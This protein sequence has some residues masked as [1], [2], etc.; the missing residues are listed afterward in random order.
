MS[1]RYMAEVAEQASA[2]L[3]EQCGGAAQ[4]ISENMI[5]GAVDRESTALSTTLETE[6][7]NTQGLQSELS[8]LDGSADSTAGEIDPDSAALST[9]SDAETPPAPEEDQGP[10]VQEAGQPAGGN[11]ST[12]NGG[13][14]PVDVVSGQLLIS[15][16]DLALP[17]VLPL[18][19][20]RAYASG[21]EDGGLYGPGWSSTLDI[22]L[23]IQDGAVSFLGDDCQRLE[24]GVPAGLRLGLPSFPAYGAR[25]PLSLEHGGSE[26][27][28]QDPLSRITWCFSATGDAETRPLAAVIDRNGNRI[29]VERDPDGAP[30]RL[31]HDGGYRVAIGMT[32][33]AESLRVTAL[34]LEP[35]EDTQPAIPVLTYEYDEAGKLSRITDSSSVPYVYE[36]ADTGR[37]SGW[38]DR[39]G[40]S[41][42]YT[43]DATGRVVHTEGDGGY[44]TAD[45]TYDP[46]HRATTVTNSLG[47]ATVYHYDRFQHL[48]EVVDQLGEHVL[49][50][51]DRYGRLIAYTD[52]LGNTTSINRDR[53]GNA[54]QLVRA[55]GSNVR[56]RFHDDGQPAE[57]VDASG[58]QWRYAYD[59][60]GN[61][62][63]VTDPLGAV[64]SYSYDE[65]GALTSITDACGA[66]SR[67]EVDAAGLTVAEIDP[68]GAV[69]RMQRDA[70]GRAIALTDPLGA[71]TRAGSTVE[72][73]RLWRENPDGSVDRWEYD[74]AGNLVRHQNAS[75]GA[76]A[77]T[78]GPFN[79]VRSRTD[80][81]GAKYSA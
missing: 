49:V 11:D 55:D 44:L 81:T 37:I 65:R 64:Q 48:T 66:T 16:T 6:A 14:D 28:V 36:W 23:V 8:G 25:W 67:Y 58:G 13:T 42:R 15:T 5:D 56:T 45:L 38:V 59:E 76:T 4:A 17:G 22:R 9:P 80:P 50:R 10:D 12:E 77:F 73:R 21:Y 74:P 72:G 43:Y 2:D 29:L 57:I 54:Q 78:Y 1:G 61:L 52:Q 46:V 30:L 53:D 31:I 3:S 70:F 19:L 40:F 35:A 18:V 41:Y 62:L 26:Y 7:R 79:R 63:S 75:G 47:H 20:R 33:I 68:L 39:N 32:R 27:H 51:H 34:T 71:V 24:Y 60:R 69:T